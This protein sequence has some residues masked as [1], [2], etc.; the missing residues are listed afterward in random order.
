MSKVT[1]SFKVQCTI[2]FY[3]QIP[4]DIQKFTIHGFKLL[5]INE[6]FT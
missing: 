4:V 2:G 1:N 3:N 5:S 6:N